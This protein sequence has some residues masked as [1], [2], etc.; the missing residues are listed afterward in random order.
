MT[1]VAQEHAV[2]VAEEEVALADR[3]RVRAADRLHAGE[4]GDEHEQRRL[5]QVEV[6][7]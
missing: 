2:A 4:G 5:R 6:R 3:L 7:Q 1:A